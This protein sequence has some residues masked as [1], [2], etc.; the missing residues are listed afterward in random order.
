MKLKILFFTS[1]ILSSSMA[2][3]QDLP[4]IIKNGETKLSASNF[5]G[6]ELDF[7]TAIRLN[8]AVTSVYLDKMKKYETMNEFQRSS[9]DMPDGFVFNHDLATPYYGHGKSLLGLGK[10]EEALKDFQM[11]ISIDPKYSDAIC[12]RGIILIATG[13]KE[14]GCMDLRKAKVLGSAKA[15]ELYEANACSGMSGSFIRSGDIKFEA[16]D[17]NGAL[18]DYT[19]AIQ[20][21]SD[22]I[23][24]YLKRAQCNVL[25]KKYDKAISDY[26]KAIKIKSD[27]IQIF[28]LRGLTYNASS[29]YKLA[30]A[31]FTSVI[32]LDPNN[33]D[34]YMQRAL[35]CEGLENFRSATFDYSEAI[36]IRPKD[37]IAYYKRGLANQDAKD[38]SACK[39]FKT[40]SGLGVEDAKPLAEGCG[41]PA[42]KR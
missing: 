7:S 23:S 33:Y 39:D 19:S 31:D 32:K 36:R 42:S 40:A 30:F 8:D 25:L 6:A 12:E 11:A 35:T 18:S 5:Q 24:P 37:G 17:Y 34:A 2:F 15:K 14:K 20:L 26:N 21:N 1:L 38:N 29:N 9:S 28:Y 27:T 3:S 16:K 13:T 4:T 10:P 41:V 22:S